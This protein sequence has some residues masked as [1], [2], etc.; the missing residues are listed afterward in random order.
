MSHNC[1]LSLISIEYLTNKQKKVL[2]NFNV[3]SMNFD[4]Y[5]I[6]ETGLTNIPPQLIYCN[7]E[8]T[9]ILAKLWKIICVIH[10]ISIKVKYIFP[11]S[12]SLK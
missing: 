1:F 11:K 4:Y 3:L 10:L 6:K 5:I 2:I 9:A 12:L 8:I 7:L